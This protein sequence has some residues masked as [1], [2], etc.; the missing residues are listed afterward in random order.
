MLGSFKSR[1]RR[2][3]RKRGLATL[4][5]V[6][7]SVAAEMLVEP[8]RVVVERESV[9]L[10]VRAPLRI[11]HL[12][13]LHLHGFGFRESEALAH[14]ERE[15]PD[16]VVV[17][18]DVTDEG[19]LDVARPFFQALSTFA[20]GRVYVVLGN[21]EHWRPV[22]DARSFYAS[23]GAR[24]LVDEGARLRD[25]VF[26]SGLDDLTAGP[27]D[28]ARALAGRP[29]GAVAIGAFH[30]PEMW[31]GPGRVFALALAGH[32]H[33]GQ[34]RLPFGRPPFTPPGS[35]RYVEGRYDDGGRTLIVSRGLGTSIAPVRLFCRPEV[36][37]IHVVPR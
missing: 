34:V 12:S 33:G 36:R 18:G 32:T 17:T 11:A 4:G 31:D 14:L 27:P 22:G 19:T 25:D 3:W 21:W 24:L 8:Y 20:S 7:V 37:I 13:D 28:M 35:G 6:A 9:T 30:S 5:V 29:P 23:V 1:F 16:V 10:D 26:L 2:G 15:R